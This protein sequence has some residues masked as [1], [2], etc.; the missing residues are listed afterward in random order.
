[1]ASSS[2]RAPPTTEGSFHGFVI[3]PSPFVSTTVG[4][5]PCAS[6]PSPVSSKSFVST[7]P[8]TSLLGRLRNRV[9]FS[10]CANCRWWLPKQVST[11]VNSPVSGS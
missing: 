11:I 7:Q 6:R 8:N 4:H 5:Q 9:S 10:S 2:K 3:R 1:M